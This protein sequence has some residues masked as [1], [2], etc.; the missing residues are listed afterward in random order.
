MSAAP[1]AFASFLAA[2][3][4]LVPLPGHWRAR[5]IPTLSLIAWLSFLNV[6]HGVNVI[7]WYDNTDIKLKIWCDIISKLVIGANMAIPASCFCLA[8]RLEGIASVRSVKRTHSD[9]RRKMLSDIAICV[10]LPLIQMALHY[11]VQG[12]RFD[13]V[14][15]FGCQPETYVSLP[16]F[17]LIWFIPILLCLGTFVLGALAFFH[18]FR[19]RATFARHLAASNTGLTPSRYFRLM[20][21]SLALM[22]WNLVVFALTLAFNYRRGLRPWTNWADVHSNWLNI[23]RFPVFL[24]PSDTLRWTYFLWW[25]IPVTAY[26][27]FAFFAFGRDALI[28]YA[29]YFSWFKR[30]VLRMRP[31]TKGNKLKDPTFVPISSVSSP[32]PPKF[33]AFPYTSQPDVPYTPTSAETSRLSYPETHYAQTPASS[34][35]SFYG[36]TEAHDEEKGHDVTTSTT[37]PMDDSE[38]VPPYYPPSSPS[39]PTT[40]TIVPP[41][42][43]LVAEGDNASII[44]HY[45]HAS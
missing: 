27:F 7:E 12:H 17:F 42:P 44:S 36:H 25:T 26:M 30:N 5:N 16:E 39:S 20:A 14:E 19:R 38:A 35:V 11:V 6:A 9:K 21:M 15:R 24:I 33:D 31:S 18:F 45:G 13:I 40:P 43:A 2:V 4:V 34:I 1:R 29:G 41:P 22:I 32:R 37:R 28:E 3:L 23:N 10:G 8:L